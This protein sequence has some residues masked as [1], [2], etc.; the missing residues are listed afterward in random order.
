MLTP[1]HVYL[2]PHGHPGLESWGSDALLEGLG[3]VE[4]LVLGFTFRLHDSVS[5]EAFGQDH[6]GMLMEGLLELGNPW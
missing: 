6:V 3:D 4:S 5:G 2:A 1:P